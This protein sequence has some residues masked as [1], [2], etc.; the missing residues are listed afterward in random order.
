MSN[1]KLNY[2][3]F[4]LV[5]FTCLYCKTKFNDK[6]TDSSYFAPI[7]LKDTSLNGLYIGL[8]EMCETDS[9]G[10]KNC[11]NDPAQPNRKWY[12]FTYLKLKGDSVFVDQS[13]INIGPK[14]D[15][16]WSAS[17]G[18]FYYYSGTFEKKDSTLKL[19]LIELFCD[20][21]GVPVQK[22]PDGTYEAIKIKKSLNGKLINNGF[23]IN[24]YVFSKKANV[25]TLISEHP[26][27]WN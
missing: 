8:E 15:T 2:T 21:C 20:Y 18:E 26:K 23:N 11:Y 17:D 19:N 5:L 6:N 25:D 22:K 7:S 3:A 10:K 16:M 4:I 13:P 12:H 24:G 27:K 9:T 14:N 1:I